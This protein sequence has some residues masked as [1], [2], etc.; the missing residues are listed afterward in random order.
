VVLVGAQDGESYENAKRS[1]N[2]LEQVKTLHWQ[3]V[4][5]RDV[6]GHDYLVMP[7]AALRRIE[8]LWG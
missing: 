6:L 7:L 3:Y 2:N 8:E 4:N 5:I 1:F